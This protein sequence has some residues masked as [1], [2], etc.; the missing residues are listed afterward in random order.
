M[1]NHSVWICLG[2]AVIVFSYFFYG[3]L[4][5]KALEKKCQAAF[6]TVYEQS[7]SRPNYA[8]KYSYGFPA[9]TVTFRSNMELEEANKNG[10]NRRFSKEIE[11][12][13]R[14]TGTKAHPFQVEQ[15]IFFA[16]EETLEH[17]RKTYSA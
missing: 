8:M 2:L 9:F 14:N 3:Y 5:L 12:L 7:S 1:S 11:E 6:H 10:V 17:L 4:K 13:C 16:S 15:A